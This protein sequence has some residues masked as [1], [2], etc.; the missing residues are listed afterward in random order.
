MSSVPTETGV[1]SIFVT[2]SPSRLANGTPRRLM[3]TNPR[4][5]T[6]LFFSTISCAR[7]TRVRSISEA[8]IKRAFSR[9][10][11]WG[12]GLWLVMNE[13][14]GQPENDTRERQTRQGGGEPLA[15]ARTE[16]GD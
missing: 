2:K 11:N 14:D 4:R 1:F 8:D 12:F 5:S 6:P 10:T 3:P 16:D 15:I 13:G 7:R 9:R